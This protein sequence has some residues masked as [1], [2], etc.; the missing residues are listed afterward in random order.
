MS[1][2]DRS[3]V[4]YCPD[5]DQDCETRVE[6][7]REDYVVRGEDISVNTAVRV[8]NACNA[9]VHDELLDEQTIQKAYN[10]YRQKHGLLSPEEICDVRERYG[11]SQRGF[12]SL[13]NW[14]PNTIA[15]YET[16]A[17]P[18]PAHMSTLI[19]LRDNIGFAR[20]L[21][22]I[23]QHML[24][25]LD[26][27]RIEQVL[28]GAC[29]D[30][31]SDLASVLTERYNKVEPLYRGFSDYDYNKVQNMVLYFADKHPRI[32]KTK[33]MKY[34]FYADFSH[35]KN[36][37]YSLSGMPYQKL[38]FGPVPYNHGLLLDTLCEEGVVSVIPFETFD[39]EYIQA[40]GEADLTVFTDEEIA[41][42]QKVV[43]IFRSFNAK[44]ISDY[45]HEEDAY[46]STEDRALVSYK[47]GDTLRNL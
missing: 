26:R 19:M 40:L 16:G 36:H 47:L 45:S 18:D 24:G 34:L 2:R 6:E 44:A 29:P 31:C 23:N 14:S 33:L 32:S 27:K 25:R 15:R 43:E 39:G 10:I 22:E 21:Y 9:P 35:F 8:C 38:P 5:C 46:T 4:S 13:L 42:L 3:N 7:R 11:L 41:S 20:Q 12:A 17:L 30:G 37:G 28:A 1:V